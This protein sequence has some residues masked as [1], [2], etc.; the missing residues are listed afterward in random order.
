MAATLASQV[1]GIIG[2]RSGLLIFLR[3]LAEQGDATFCSN[4]RPYQ[5]NKL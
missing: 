5:K 2:R 3:E 1:G 4:A